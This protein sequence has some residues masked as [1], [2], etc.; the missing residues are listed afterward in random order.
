VTNLPAQAVKKL[1][2]YGFAIDFSVETQDR[3]NVCS[4]LRASA[5]K[6]LLS[7]AN[8]N[9]FMVAD[10]PPVLFACPFNSDHPDAFAVNAE[11]DGKHVTVL[12]SEIQTDFCVVL[13][14]PSRQD[15]QMVRSE[16]CAWCGRLLNPAYLT[17]D[18]TSTI[19]VLDHGDYFYVYKVFE[20]HGVVDKFIP[21]TRS[22]SIRMAFA[23]D[24]GWLILSTKDVLPARCDSMPAGMP[25]SIGYWFDSAGKE[26]IDRKISTTLPRFE[27]ERRFE[28]LKPAAR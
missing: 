20:Q 17:Q 13:A 3:T 5:T 21:W 4:E 22:E 7:V 25:F 1:R 24:G 16:F 2:D 10:K 18:N 12:V 14:S 19:D 15:D 11:L 26:N 23:K 27:G 8:T 6:R 9:L 28:D